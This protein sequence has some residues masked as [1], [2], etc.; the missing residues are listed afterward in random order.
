M[1]I[2]SFPLPEGKLNFCKL[3]DFDELDSDKQ[4]FLKARGLHKTGLKYSKPIFENTEQ[5]REPYPAHAYYKAGSQASALMS[6][7]TMAFLVFK[8]QTTQIEISQEIQSS[9]TREV[10]VLERYIRQSAR[11]FVHFYDILRYGNHEIDIVRGNEPS[12]GYEFI[13][14]VLQLRNG[15]KQLPPKWLQFHYGLNEED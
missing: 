13:D 5:K 3:V 8:S 6:D 10:I 12:E 7:F 2:M 11:A 15:E 14:T 9:P 4:K 1:D